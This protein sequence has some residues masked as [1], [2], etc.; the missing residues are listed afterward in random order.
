MQERVFMD[1]LKII[2]F[3]V[4]VMTFLLV[5]G[6]LYAFGLIYKKASHPSAAAVLSLNQP[7]GSYIADYSSDNDNL[8]LLIKGGQLSDRIVV[9]NQNSPTLTINLN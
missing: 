8:Y 3:V 7:K 4:A 9:V 6:S 5:F 1:K 2:K